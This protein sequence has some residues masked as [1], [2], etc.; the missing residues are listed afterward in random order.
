LFKFNE[1]E[2][3]MIE[4]ENNSGA[5]KEFDIV[6]RKTL[7]SHQIIRQYYWE[8]RKTTSGQ[9]GFMKYGTPYFDCI[10]FCSYI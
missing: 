9:G 5:G 8:R 6:E 2:A 7:G 4:G 10:A 1:R 3:L